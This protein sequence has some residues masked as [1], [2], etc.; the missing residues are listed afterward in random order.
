M[1]GVERDKR[2][3]VFFALWPGKAQR[4]ALAAWQV[5][6]K[7]M[8]GGRMMRTET[9]HLT[10][11]FLGDVAPHRLEAL[12]LAAREI[13]CAPFTLRLDR[14]RYWGHNHI[15]YAAPTE[16]PELLRQLVSELERKLHRHRFSFDRRRYQPHVTL[17]RHA[18]WSDEPLPAMPAISW[19]VRQFVLVQS[20]SDE[21]GARYQV[22]ARFLL[23]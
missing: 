9:L 10:L 5:A 14:A 8:C 19:R 23:A 6:L 18:R 12:Q 13:S 7:K 16:A 21:N 20:L 2:V 22:L 1:D 17:L 15:A 4:E 11:V 3:R